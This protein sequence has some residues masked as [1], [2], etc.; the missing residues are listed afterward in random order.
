[1]QQKGRFLY[2]SITFPHLISSTSLPICNSFYS[3]YKP[4]DDCETLSKIHVQLCTHTPSPHM[5]LQQREFKPASLSFLQR[6]RIEIVVVLRVLACRH[7]ALSLQSWQLPTVQQQQLFT[8]INHRAPLLWYK[9][10]KTCHV[11]LITTCSIIAGNTFTMNNLESF[12]EAT[13]WLPLIWCISWA[14]RSEAVLLK[15]LSSVPNVSVL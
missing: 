6:S 8:P 12:N 5:W 14:K 7:F 10:E 9:S 1:M 2:R 4:E 13:F 15:C 11:L 3:S